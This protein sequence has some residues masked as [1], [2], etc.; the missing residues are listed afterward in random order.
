MRWNFG[1]VALLLAS[2]FALSGIGAAQE[3]EWSNLFDGSTLQGWVKRG[4]EAPYRVEDGAIVG[5]IVPGKKDAEG[6]IV[7]GTP[8]TF[9]C[10][11]KYYGDFV[12]ELEFKVDPQMNSGVQVRS[13]S[14]DSY[15]NGRVHGYQV[16]IDPSA[17]A[18]TGGIYDEARR[19]WLFDLGGKP[20]AQKDTPALQK[21]RTAFKQNEWN[22]FR[23]EAKGSRIKTWVNGVPVS[24]LKDDM[25]KRGFIAL[26][27]HGS[28]E[29]EPIEVRWRNIRIQALT[30]AQDTPDPAEEGKLLGWQKKKEAE[31]K[32][33][34]AKAEK[35]EQQ[36][37]KKEQPGRGGKK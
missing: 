4:G 12:L 19:G 21:A 32:K 37:A 13:N 9:L 15:D 14:F 8:N 10:T 5:T 24:D 27:V 20:G 1:F 36:R 17:R 26:Q 25:T 34:A 2:M 31:K 30:P 22:R 29:L 23:V 35:K 16:E 33:E 11:E 3:A 28:K 7:S 6:K 18:W